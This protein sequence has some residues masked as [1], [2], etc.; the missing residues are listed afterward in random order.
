MSCIINCTDL[1][2]TCTC[3]IEVP[4]KLMILD[5]ETDG[6][7]LII[8]IAYI[9]IHDGKK[10]EKAYILQNWKNKTDYYG[11][12]SIADLNKYGK[13]PKDVIKQVLN[14]YNSCDKIIGHNIIFD[15]NKIKLYA[16]KYQ[17]EMKKI[18]TYDT[19]KESRLIVNALNKNGGVKMPKLC[20]ACAHF[21]IEIVNAHNA[22]GDI[23]A[24]YKLYCKLK[25][26]H[27]V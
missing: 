19:M 22:I 21:G 27:T 9:I 13:H 11:T 1:I 5:I 18:N 3:L 8:Q 4:E 24:T 7:N 15:I 25:N 26:F 20:E 16:D 23:E 6:Y 17:Y 2:E 14:D 12:I 10:I